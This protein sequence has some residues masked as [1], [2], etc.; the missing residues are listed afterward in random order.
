M[1]TTSDIIRKQI[2]EGG[3]KTIELFCKTNGISKGVVFQ[4]IFTNKWSDK[5]LKRIGDALGKDLTYLANT[6]STEKNERKI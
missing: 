3:Y 6:K 1:I 4:C 2:K 5:H